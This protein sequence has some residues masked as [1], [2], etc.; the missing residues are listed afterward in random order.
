MQR[1]GFRIIEYKQTRQYLNNIEFEVKENEFH[2]RNYLNTVKV[3]EIDIVQ[4]CLMT[5]LGS[6]KSIYPR[7]FSLQISVWYSA[8]NM[9][10]MS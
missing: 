3:V 8:A 9:R 10:A 2:I 4:T 1:T 7:P 6:Y 5:Y